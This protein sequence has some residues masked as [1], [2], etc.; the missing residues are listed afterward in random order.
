MSPVFITYTLLIYDFWGPQRGGGREGS[1]APLDPPAT[2]QL[3]LQNRLCSMSTSCHIVNFVYTHPLNSKFTIWHNY[4]QYLWTFYQCSQYWKYKGDDI[5][6][7][8][9]KLKVYDNKDIWRKTFTVARILPLPT[10]LLIYRGISGGSRNLRTGGCGPG[11]T[12]LNPPL[13]IKTNYNI[14]LS[15][16]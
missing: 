3:D 16:P 5:R 11:A 15:F 6:I 8:V 10:A 12:A 4:H 9:W 14:V 13:G 2:S 1:D 7:Y